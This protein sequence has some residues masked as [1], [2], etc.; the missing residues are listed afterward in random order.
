ME[1]V[2][3]NAGALFVV[4]SQLNGAEYPSDTRVLA[5]AKGVVHH[6][7]DYKSYAHH[8]GPRAQLAAHPAAA[9]FL[10]DNAATEKN[11]KGI[12]AIDAI[13]EIE[14]ANADPGGSKELKKRLHRL[15]LLVMEHVSTGGLVPKLSAELS[16]SRGAFANGSHRVGLVYA[17][18]VPVNASVNAQD[19]LDPQDYEDQ[20]KAA[21]FFMPVGAG[22]S[23]NPWD[24]IGKSM[25]MAI[26]MLDH[27]LHV[28]LEISALTFHANPSE[29][30]SLV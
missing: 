26:Q 16:G 3:E 15:R 21:V 25:A 9:Q 28:T 7:E 17:S 8:S 18:A 20:T 6:V 4:P 29:E 10:L 22:S 27:N 13:A 24:T 11:P 12:N 23:Q 1:L 19:P 14:G 5:A 30:Q 2:H